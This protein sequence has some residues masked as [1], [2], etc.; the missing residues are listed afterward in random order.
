MDGFGFEVG[1]TYEARQYHRGNL[2][3]TEKVKVVYK[4]SETKRITLMDTHGKKKV[5]RYYL[6][7]GG[8]Q[9]LA[10]EYVPIISFDEF[11]PYFGVKAINE[12]A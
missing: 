4:N 8:T 5:R 1:K 9:V 2:L 7:N 3:Y 11:G 12:V 10:Y 6:E